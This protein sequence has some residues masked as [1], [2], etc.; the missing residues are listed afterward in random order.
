MAQRRLNKDT[1]QRAFSLL[2]EL[3]QQ[4]EQRYGSRDDRFGVVDILQCDDGPY[5]HLAGTNVTL[6]VGPNATK[7]EPTLVSN[8]AHECVHL[9]NPITGNASTLEEGAAVDFELG[10]I[11]SRFGESE[12]E[13]FRNFLPDTYRCALSDVRD[14]LTL[15]SSAILRIR[16]E[17]GGLTG[18]TIQD[19]ERL[20][21]SIDHGLAVRLVRRQRMRGG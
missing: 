17:L 6:F 18:P 14:L 1:E 9:L 5:I 20:V 7:Y 19:L 13:H 3:L 16:S 2:D 8:I 4:A 12:I 10:A 21:P 11:L 15:D